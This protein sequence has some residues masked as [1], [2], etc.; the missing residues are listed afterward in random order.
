[1]NSSTIKPILTSHSYLLPIYTSTNSYTTHLT[2]PSTTLK[3]SKCVVEFDTNYPGNDLSSEGGVFSPNECCRIC[4]SNLKCFAWSYFASFNY[5]FLKSNAPSASN[6]NSK[7][8]Y[9]GIW[10]GVVNRS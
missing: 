7:Q 10:S 4:S 5:C 2:P 1:M 9:E 8:T 3:P 6:S